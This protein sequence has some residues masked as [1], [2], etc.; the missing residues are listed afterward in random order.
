M[1]EPK[2]FD[3]K[4]T[5]ME[6]EPGTYYWCSCGHSAKQPFCD[7][8]HQG[9]EFTPVVFELTEKKSVALCLCKYTKNT[10]FCDGSHTR[11]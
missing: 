5:V 1:S 9:T 7:G 3:K 4:P 8:S 10:P 2:I 6:L 11:L